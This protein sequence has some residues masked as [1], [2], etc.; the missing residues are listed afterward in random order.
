MARYA[1]SKKASW[2]PKDGCGSFAAG[3]GGISDIVKIAGTAAEKDVAGE[4]AV[5][6]D[7][8]EDLHQGGF[9]GAVFADEGVDLALFEHE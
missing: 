6:I 9:S 3:G 4:T 2:W 1:P 8:R 7:A 5:R